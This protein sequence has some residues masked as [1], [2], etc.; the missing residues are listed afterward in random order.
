MAIPLAIRQVFWRIIFIYMGAAFFF[1]LTCPADAD[2]LQNGPSRALQSPMTIAI[3]NAGWYGGVHLINSFILIT[4][5]SAINSSIYISSRTLLFMGQDRKAPK[6]LGW[7][8][9]RG[10]SCL[11][12][13]FLLP[14]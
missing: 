8:D 13:E 14:L 2:G 7:T 4:C 5:V 9:K 3:Q 6:F 12:P 10:V 1:G 11:E